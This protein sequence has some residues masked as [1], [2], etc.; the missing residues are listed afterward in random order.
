[1][2]KSAPPA[3]A[4][5]RHH[6]GRLAGALLLA[7]TRPAWAGPQHLAIPGGIARLLL[8]AG[9]GTPTA[10]LGQRHV[11][12]IHET[13]GFTAIVGIGLDTPTGPLRLRWQNGDQQ[14]ELAFAVTPHDYAT[15]RVHVKDRRKVTPNAEDEARI[16][17]EQE[18]IS[19]LKNHWRESA[20]PDL[21]FKLPASGPLSGRFGL[22]RIF[23]GEPRAPHA[24]L[25]LALASGTP[26]DAPAAGVVLDTG[27]YFFNGL[28]VFID[29]GQGLLSMLCHLSRID[30]Q[31]GEAVARGQLV[32]HSGASGRASGPHLHWTV[33]LNGVAVDPELFL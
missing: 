12:V 3:S 4:S 13:A 2:A 31:V 9:P 22:R 27:D 25:D 18:H 26:V 16:A 8:P 19:T 28:T 5:R 14:G 32:G 29:H 24:G 33:L 23:N 21:D 6:L 7:C 1:M 10:W 11:M 20:A 15:Q 17:V 30:V